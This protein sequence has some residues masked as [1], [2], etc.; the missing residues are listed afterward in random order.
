MAR[1][2]LEAQLDA[3]DAM[4]TDDLKAEWQRIHKSPPPAI[5]RGLLALALGYQLQ[6]IAMGKMSASTRDVLRKSENLGG[7]SA[8]VPSGARLMRSWNG[9]TYVVETGED[10]TIRWNNREWRSLSE[11][12]RAITGT[13]WSGPAFFGLRVKR[14]A[15][16]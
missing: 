12:A 15:A 13:R 1:Q 7:R 14:Q 5:S 6:C 16:A 3:I 2:S 10:G 8:P 9:Q 11:V 4:T